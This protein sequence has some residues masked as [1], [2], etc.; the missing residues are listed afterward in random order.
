V[1]SFEIPTK[2]N[3]FGVREKENGIYSATTQ[4][5]NRDKATLKK[6]NNMT[7]RTFW[8][9]LLKI[10]G[11]YLVFDSFIV[12]PQF[13]T[14][15]STF[16]LDPEQTAM[17]FIWTFVYLLFTV[18]LFVFILWLFVF[19]TAWLIDKL[20]LE[21]GFSEERIEFNIPHSTVLSISIILIGGLMF[22]D[23]LPQLCRQI[24]SFFQQKNMFIQDPSSDLI[25]FHFVKTI[26]GYLLMTNSRF[27]VNFIDGKKKNENITNE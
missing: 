1:A 23:S 16:F 21:K 9:I 5:R 12:I 10:L 18:G 19:K 6:H 3:I 24:F 13:L 27:I 2:T 11:I 14:T 22:V 15:L 20:H 26:I 8:T 7:I 4:S 17:V 25:I